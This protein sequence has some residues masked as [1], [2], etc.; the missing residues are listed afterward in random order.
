MQIIQTAQL[1]N[2]KM[3]IIV[4]ENPESPREWDNLGKMICW[5]RRYNLGDKDEYKPN[6]REFNEWI[7]KQKAVVL[8]LYMYDHSGITIRTYPFSSR[9]DSRQIG[10]IYATYEDIRKK[11]KRKHIT[12]KL[13]ETTKQALINEVKVYDMY[14]R[15]DVY[16]F[17]IVEL[18]KCERCGHV[19]EKP[20]DSCY[21]FYGSD[22]ELNGLFG[23]VD[24]KWKN[25]E[26]K[27]AH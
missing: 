7:Q 15:G 16:G 27:E 18:I 11:F 2:E 13:L 25:A 12:Q 1:D 22:F 19:D 4:D 6:P 9:W 26:W 3:T 14:V 17:E 5:H 10:F 24:K 20:T 23:H 8:P 21:G